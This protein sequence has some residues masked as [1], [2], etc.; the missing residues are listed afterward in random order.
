MKWNDRITIARTK[1]GLSK[2]QF[3]KA[4]G[5]SSATATNWENGKV[6]SIKGENLFKACALLGVTEQWLLHGDESHAEPEL[7]A[8]TLEL[9]CFMKATDERGRQDMLRA[10]QDAFTLRKAHLERLQI[11]KEIDLLAYR[12]P[13]NDAD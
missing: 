1:K 8:E 13:P 3:W 2:T 10:A 11:I 5:I 4:M 9:I 12:I 7:D 6:T